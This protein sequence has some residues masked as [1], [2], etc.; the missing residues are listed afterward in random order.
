[1]IFNISLALAHHDQFVAVE[2]SLL[3]QAGPVVAERATRLRVDQLEEGRRRRRRV[4]VTVAS[5]GWVG[6]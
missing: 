3:R 1:M 2:D 6:E 4:R 5:Y